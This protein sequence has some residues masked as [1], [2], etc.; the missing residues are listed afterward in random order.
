MGQWLGNSVSL[1]DKISLTPNMQLIIYL[2]DY[3]T[4]ENITEAAFDYFSITDYS[5]LSSEEEIDNKI[6]LE[7]FPNPFNDEIILSQENLMVKIYNFSG[8]LI[9]ESRN[10][11]KINTTS[12]N[13]GL[14]LVEIK[15]SNNEL[16]KVKKII[17]L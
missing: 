9:L 1:T 7:V 12:L 4:S 15:N 17:K 6:D 11:T 2:S 10:E 8:Q 13:A 16:L 3:V 14:Y 5:V